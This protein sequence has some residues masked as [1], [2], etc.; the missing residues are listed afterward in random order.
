VN[1]LLML[2]AAALLLAGGVANADNLKGTYSFVGHDD[3]W[4]TN[5]PLIPPPP[6]LQLN[7]NGGLFSMVMIQGGAQGFATFNGD[8]TGS[9]NE[10][11]SW[12]TYND[13]LNGW[14]PNLRFFSVAPIQFT[15]AFTYAVN[16]DEFT[17]TEASRT[18]L[19][20][21]EALPGVSV[22]TGMP[23]VN[24]TISTNGKPILQ[25]F[26]GTAAQETWRSPACIGYPPVGYAVCLRSRTYTKVKD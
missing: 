14:V 16:G 5:N 17:L 2:T 19:A 3:C 23:T 7:E 25:T 1:R 9:M 11:G 13:N 20:Q 26:T 22:A 15:I 18:G 6:W 21:S 8:G 4:L 24:G 12:L 10:G